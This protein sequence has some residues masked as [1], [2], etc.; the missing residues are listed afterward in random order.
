MKIA[1]IVTAGWLY[2]FGYQNTYSE[3]IGSQA[4]FADK[5]YLVMSWKDTT[6]FPELQ[7]AHPNIELICDERTWYAANE[8]DHSPKGFHNRNLSIGLLTAREAGYD[9]GVCCHSNWYIP[10]EAHKGIQRECQRVL[11]ERDSTG[12][13]YRADQLWNTWFEPSGCVRFINNLTLPY[14]DHLQ[15]GRVADK[16]HRMLNKFPHTDCYAVDVPLEMSEPDFQSV[17]VWSEFP[18]ANGLKAYDYGF[19]RDFYIRRFMHK[20]RSQR[21]LDETGKALA[22]KSQPDYVSHDVLK[23]LLRR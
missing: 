14:T 11:D 20:P 23:G 7:K 9:I 8:N 2:K 22:D 1:F 18:Q 10:R 16:T 19:Y 17:M 3:C 21:P 15:P 12:A 5:V 6:N 13:L 4:Q